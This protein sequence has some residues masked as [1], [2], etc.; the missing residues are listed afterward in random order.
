MSV[1]PPWESVAD[2]H[3]ETTPWLLMNR[4]WAIRIGHFTVGTKRSRKHARHPAHKSVTLGSTH[5][6][7]MLVYHRESVAD[8]H[9]ISSD[10]E[11]QRPPLTVET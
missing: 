7:V 3:I 5:C 10:I 1:F 8:I 2:I 6:Q 4:V 11:S 9:S